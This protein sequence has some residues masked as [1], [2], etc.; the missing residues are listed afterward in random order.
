[1][2]RVLPVQERNNK[3]KRP[4][5]YIAKRALGGLRKFSAI[6]KH[7]QIFDLAFRMEM[8]KQILPVDGKN[9]KVAFLLQASS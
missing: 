9:E 4:L 7:R 3:E 2:Y 8:Q 5:R 6:F 1:M